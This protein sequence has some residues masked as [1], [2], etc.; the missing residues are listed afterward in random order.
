MLVLSR[1]V[2]EIIDMA[3]GIEIQV[4]GVNGGTVKLGFRAPREIAIHRRDHR[5]KGASDVS[6]EP[7]AA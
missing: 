2:D 3:G 5:E 4:L 6:D 1:K 7:E